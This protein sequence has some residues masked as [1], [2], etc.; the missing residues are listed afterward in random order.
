MTYAWWEDLFRSWSSSPRFLPEQARKTESSAPGNTKE[1][2]SQMNWHMVFTYYKRMSITC[3]PIQRLCLAGARAEDRR[4]KRKAGSDCVDREGIW[5]SSRVFLAEGLS[6]LLTFQSVISSTQTHHITSQRARV[7]G[8]QEPS[9]RRGE[10]RKREES[11]SS[12]CSG[13][14]ADF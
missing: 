13:T 8:T 11:P 14:W 12:S 7:K 5:M 1:I 2:E 9:P 6:C 3:L 10:R 4:K